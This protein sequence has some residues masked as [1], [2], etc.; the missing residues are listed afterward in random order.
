MQNVGT[1]REPN[2]YNNLYD[3]TRAGNNRLVKMLCHKP[4]HA[5][6]I[7]STLR[8]DASDLTS[9]Q[10]KYIALKADQ[11]S[12][13]LNAPTVGKYSLTMQPDTVPV[14]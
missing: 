9:D 7:Q 14:K 1:Y 2:L 6:L 5:S 11:Q 4:Q 3:A 12:V 13:I 10:L 8:L